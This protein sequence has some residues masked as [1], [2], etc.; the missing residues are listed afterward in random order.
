[1]D[2]TQLGALRHA[3]HGAMYPARPS[4]LAAHARARHASEAVVR[5]LA[6]LPDRP[7]VGPDQVCMTLIG[8]FA[9]NECGP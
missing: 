9:Q 2:R 7:I 8:R 3:L 5:A 4:Q 1:M 6:A